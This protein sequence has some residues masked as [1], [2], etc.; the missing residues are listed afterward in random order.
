[1]KEKEDYYSDGKLLIKEFY[2]VGLIDK[3]LENLSDNEK[4][5]KL[6]HDFWEEWIKED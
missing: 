4:G 6:K 2:D 5:Q 1:M 3:F